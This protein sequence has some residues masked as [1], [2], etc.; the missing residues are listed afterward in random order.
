MKTILKI[1]SPDRIKKI[2]KVT[3][4]NGTI[5]IENVYEDKYHNFYLKTDLGNICL[6]EFNNGSWLQK[7]FKGEKK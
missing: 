3:Y 1:D 5:G 2:V 7:F 4:D 6:T